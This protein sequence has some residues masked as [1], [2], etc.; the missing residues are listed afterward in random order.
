[1]ANNLKVWMDDLSAPTKTATRKVAKAKAR[2]KGKGK[3]SAIP[4]PALPAK[5]GGKGC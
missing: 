1:M 5:F 2:K 3:A 4:L